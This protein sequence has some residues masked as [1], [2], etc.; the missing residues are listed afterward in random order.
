MLGKL[1]SGGAAELVKGVGGV[2][3]KDFT[4]VIEFQ[5]DILKKFSKELEAYWN[6]GQQSESKELVTD[7]EN[8]PF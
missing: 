1:F 8:L 5:L 4:K 2:E 3:K 6:N 7:E